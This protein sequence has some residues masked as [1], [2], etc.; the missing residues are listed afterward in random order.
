M[1]NDR[2]RI[3]GYDLARALAVFGMVVVNFKV[4]MGAEA[5]APAW[6]RWSLGILDGRAAATFVVLA[7]AGISL[8]SRQSRRSGDIAALAGDRA[9]LFRRAVFLFVVG[10]AYSP[11][12]PADIL[13]F[14]GIY[15][16]VAALFLRA[17]SRSLLG[18]AAGLI[19][20]FMVLLFSL[21]YEAGWDWDALSY[22]GFWTAPGM[23][24]HLFFNG[25]HPVVPWLGFVF[26][27]MVLGQLD[28]TERAV[29]YRVLRWSIPL[30]VSAEGV[31]WGLRALV[32]SAALPANGKEDLLAVFGTAPMP[33]VVLYMVAAAGTAVSAVTVC[34]ALGIRYRDSAWMKPLVATGQMALTLYVAHVVIGMGI[35]EAAGVLD[36]QSLAVAFSSAVIFCVAGVVFAATWRLRFRRGPLEWV[37]RSL[38]DPKTGAR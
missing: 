10:L 11:I 5:N 14:Y 17:S 2:K 31:G 36:N 18:G 28:L 21:N 20:F 33:P 23:L 34:A 35:L 30:A 26:V 37:M 8:L 19:V 24:R 32:N 27:G 9:M 29:R 15:I 6:A 1:E 16:A 7:G 25:F 13:H 22:E 12:W 38:T 3:L 4:V